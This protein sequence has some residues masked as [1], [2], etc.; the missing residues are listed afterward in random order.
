MVNSKWLMVNRENLF[1][2]FTINHLL[3]T[4]SCHLSRSRMIALSSNAP[5]GSGKGNFIHVSG[6]GP[7][8][9][10]LSRRERRPE[11]PAAGQQRS[12]TVERTSQSARKRLPPVFFL[13]RPGSAA[14]LRA[15]CC[16]ARSASETGR[17]SA[18]VLR[19]QRMSPQFDAKELK[20][21]KH[22]DC[23]KNAGAGV[24]HPLE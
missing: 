6:R 9:V 4:S 10:K 12:V 8:A 7:S 16:Y 23:E 21:E 24:G 11:F 15:L 13:L 5:A 2:L 14:R 18:P 19:L 17:F 20:R 22:H 3:F 1:F